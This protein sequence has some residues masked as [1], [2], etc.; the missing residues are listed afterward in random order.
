MS[1][2]EKKPKCPECH[3][4][5][6][7]RLRGYNETWEKFRCLHCENVYQLTKKAES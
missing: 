3:K 5:T 2:R 7:Q 6:K 1:A 4:T